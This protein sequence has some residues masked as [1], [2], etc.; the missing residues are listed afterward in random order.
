MSSLA[1]ER[2]DGM[3]LNIA[4]QSQGIEPLLDAVFS[5]LRRKTDFFSGAAPEVRQ[6][7]LR[8]LLSLG[9]S[10][11][12]TEHRVARQ[13]L[14]VTITLVAWLCL[15]GSGDGDEVREEAERLG[16]PNQDREGDQAGRAPAPQTPHSLYRQSLNLY[17]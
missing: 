5:F 9:F 16:G 12:P 3:L 6:K 13:H 8:R 17:K 4:Q 7:E 15:G 2:F 11:G 1:D 14:N 10:E